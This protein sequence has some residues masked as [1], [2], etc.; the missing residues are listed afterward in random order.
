MDGRL[1]ERLKI[2]KKELADLEQ[3]FVSWLAKL[4]YAE[5]AEADWSTAWK[6]HYKPERIGDRIVV[7]PSWEDY[8]C[9]GEELVVWLDPGMAFGTGNHPTTAMMIRAL[10]KYLSPGISV[11]DVGTGSGILAIVAAILGAK[12]VLALDND[13]LAVEIAQQNAELNNVNDRV[14]VRY[15]DLLAGLEEQ[16]QMIIANITADPILVLAG[17]AF[18]RLSPGGLFLVSGIIK[19]RRAEVE[20]E[21][22]KL[23]YKLEEAFSEGEW[24]SLV[25][26]KD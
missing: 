22:E 18:M 10:E 13:T 11:V 9:Q 2:F 1:K 21:L 16:Y 8:Q 25:A 14:T 20:A 15:N 3:H 26:R 23:G 24:T 7:S 19:H 17:E 6:A 5:I 12:S 4:S